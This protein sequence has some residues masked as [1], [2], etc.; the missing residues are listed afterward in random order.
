MS[1]PLSPLTPSVSLSCTLFPGPPHTHQSSYLLPSPSHLKTQQVEHWFRTLLWPDS[2]RPDISMM[3]SAEALL[4]A[5]IAL[6]LAGLGCLAVFTSS[7]PPLLPVLLPVSFS[8]CPSLL[9]W[10]YSLLHCSR[11]PTSSPPPSPGDVVGACA[12]LIC[13]GL[14]QELVPLTGVLPGHS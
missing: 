10:L 11:V 9:L 5:S 8:P 3:R 2:P 6:G 1:M 7:S 14:S 13:T 4:P 12:L